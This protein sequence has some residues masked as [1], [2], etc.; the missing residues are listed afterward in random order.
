MEY[1]SRHCKVL[2][3]TSV[4]SWE[5]NL[6]TDKVRSEAGQPIYLTQDEIQAIV[7]LG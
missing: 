1:T 5:R 3:N 2:F 6:I 7:Q 4:N